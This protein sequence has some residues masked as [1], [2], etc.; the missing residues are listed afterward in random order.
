MKSHFSLAKTLAYRR[1]RLGISLTALAQRSGVSLP[2]V[3]RILSGKK[4]AAID[5][6]LSV[7]SALGMRL[8]LRP[9]VHTGQLRQR[10]AKEKAKRLVAMVQGTSSL[11]GQAIDRRTY[12]RMVRVT[13]RQLLAGPRRRLWS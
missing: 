1:R 8:R 5:N 11:E 6:I 13:A 3:H 4:G 12:R 10:Q 2:T 9:V 7:A